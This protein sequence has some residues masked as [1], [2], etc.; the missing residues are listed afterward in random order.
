MRH[1]R[2]DPVARNYSQ[3]RPRYP[4]ALIAHLAGKIR[5]PG[6]TD[7]ATTTALDIGSG[8]GAFTRRLRDALPAGMHI[9]GVEPNR[10]MMAQAVVETG[11]DTGIVFVAGAAEAMPFA[12][13]SAGAVVAAT[14][15]HWFERPAFYREAQRVLV[16]GGVLAIVE[17]ARDETDPLAAA[18]VRFMAQ[19]GS[20]R[21]Y[22]PPDYR[23]ELAAADGFDGIDA[24][25]LP[26]RLEL[27]LD[28]FIGLALSS[29]H[30]AGVVQRFGDDGARDALRELA[31]PCRIDPCRI[32][33]C[34][35][36][37]AR[38]AFGYRFSCVSVQRSPR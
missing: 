5:P 8:T 3:Y 1:T 18:L 29:S 33:P 20:P 35:I 19:Y 12:D 4:D 2:Y 31:E 13:D 26:R 17:Y 7:G 30:A 6:A 22:A 14:A 34:R 24:F 25:V 11:G 32:D 10:R 37:E 27:R 16:P 15:A 9:V 38:V 21:A 28:E 36:D 23:A